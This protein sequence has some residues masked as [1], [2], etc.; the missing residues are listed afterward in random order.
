MS[1]LFIPSVC[2][3][4]V[5]S[6]PFQIHPYIKLKGILDDNI[7]LNAEDE[8]ESFISEVVPG[9]NL[10]LLMKTYLFGL[11]YYFNLVNY[12]EESNRNNI[13]KQNLIVLADFNFPKRSYFKLNTQFMETADPPTT[14][15]TERLKHRDTNLNA[16]LG[17]ELGKK[18]SFE[19]VSRYNDYK[20]EYKD[21]DYSYYERNEIYTGPTVFIKILPK[22]AIL[23]EGNYGIIN[24]ETR[25]NDSTYSQV[26][27]GFK[28]EVTP[29]CSF[30]IKGGIEQ[31]NYKPESVE[32]FST[33]I[34]NIEMTERFSD[35]TSVTF[36]AERRAYESFY[37][38]NTYFNSTQGS[39]KFT[40]NLDHKIVAS[41]ELGGYFNTYPQGTTEKS[42]SQKREDIISDAT[43]GVNYK[44]QEW[45]SLEVAHRYRMRNSNFDG[46]DYK[47]N[48]SSINIEFTF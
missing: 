7:Y 34:F 2:G 45:L 32:D 48:Q 42:I 25:N 4:D 35:Y 38:T 28:K 27:T 5:G 41:L 39:L 20:Y 24:Y 44:I 23:I 13:Q 40:Q 30:I 21:L 36:S 1:F 11:N 26:K 18:T 22:T 17:F 8:K 43:I 29:R 9:L 15:L 12:T 6:E 16:K 19:V 37:L 46:W 14:E 31:R 10:K 3:A 33:G 47:N